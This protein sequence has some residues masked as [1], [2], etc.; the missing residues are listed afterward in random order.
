VSDA[1]RAALRV[2][3]D[4]EDLTTEAMEAAM[5][6][7]LAGE[8]AEAQ[9]A[10][11]AV[12]LRMKGETADEIAAAARVMRRRCVS[13]SVSSDP[14]EVVVDTCGTGGDGAGS[15]NVSTVAAFVVAATGV[16]VAKHGN[17]AVS[18][19]SGSA[20]VLEALGARLDLPPDEVAASVARHGIGF[21]FAPAHHG[22]LRH[23]APVRR[24]LG[25]RTFFN[26]LGPLS[27]P[28]GATHQLVGVYDPSRLSQVAEVL[29]R[30]GVKGAWVVHGEGGLDEVSPLGPTRVAVL[31][32]GA[33]TERVVTPED[34]GLSVAGPDA[35]AGGDAEENAAIARRV[36]SGEG[37][38]QR[39]AVVLNAAAALLAAGIESDPRVAADRASGVLDDGRA[40][41]L[42]DRFVAHGR[43]AA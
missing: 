26:L 28:A 29:G 21:L 2:V 3:V 43:D 14:D 11:L 27:N 18:S 32:G 41:D 34:F 7:I 17:R 12:A 25:L 33:V 31:G 6:A 24:A 35:I 10:G 5:E 39:A 38:P 9:I 8:A 22:A 30:L 1:M 42:L 20:D 16:K 15:F 4:R 36:L 37:V 13:V 19:R 40:K 23:A